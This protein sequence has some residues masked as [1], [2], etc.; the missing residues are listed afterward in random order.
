MINIL[1]TLIS[2][3]KMPLKETQAREKEVLGDF[4]LMMCEFTQKEGY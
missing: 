3:F 4:T 2:R 1:T